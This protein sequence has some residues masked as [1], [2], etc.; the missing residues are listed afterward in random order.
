MKNNLK[1]FVLLSILPLV[2]LANT[3]ET[4]LFMGFVYILLSVI[5]YFTGKL[6]NQ[7]ANG[8]GRVYTYI[9]LAASIITVTMTVLNTYFDLNQ[10]MAIYLALTIFILPQLKSKSLNDVNTLESMLMIV[11]GFIILTI[12]GF[13]RECLGTGS[14]SFLAFGMDTIKVFGAEYGISILKDGSGGFIMSGFVFA[15]FNAIPFTKEDVED[16]V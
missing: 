4:A 12:I 1:S 10:F 16:V 7:Y 3:L 5:I 13:L 9:I 15:V 11:S 14:I 2:Y 6:I 8:R